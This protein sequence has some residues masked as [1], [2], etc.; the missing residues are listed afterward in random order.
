MHVR[1][2]HFGSGIQRKINNLAVLLKVAL[3]SV[4][5]TLNCSPFYVLVEI[6]YREAQMV[7]S[8]FFER[9]LFTTQNCLVVPA[10]FI[11]FR[12]A[13]FIPQK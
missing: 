8:F 4:G 11:N 3:P 5:N 2:L 9:N 6:V 13:V 10:I 1:K 12:P 7:F